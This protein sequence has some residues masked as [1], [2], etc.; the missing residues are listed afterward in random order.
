LGGGVNRVTQGDQVCWVPVQCIE[1]LSRMPAYT[2]VPA[3]EMAVGG[4][5]V[6]G[7]CYQGDAG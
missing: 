6:C 5:L 4:R 1:S 7:E 3:E 2:L